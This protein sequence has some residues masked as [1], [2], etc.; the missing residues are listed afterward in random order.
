MSSHVSLNMADSAS[1]RCSSPDAGMELAAAA[2]FLRNGGV[3]VFPT[4]TFYG[5]GCLA[6]NAEAVARVYQLKQRPVHKPLPLLAAHAAQVDA[7]AELAAMPKGLL[8]FWPGPLTVLLPARSCLPPALVN[9]Q[10][11]AAVRVTPHPLAAQLAEQAGG[12][13]T[14]SSAN[15]S[16]GAPVCSPDKLD[17]VLL[18]A[19]RSMAQGMTCPAGCAAQDAK[20]E[21]PL[22]LAFGGPLPAGGLP[23]T[24]VE[25]LS[26]GD[27][28]AGRL[29]IVRA[30]AVSAAALE[31]AGFILG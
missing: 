9:G 14:A 22:P 19:L 27:G 29:R 26:G 21:V 12:A 1:E 8:A 20:T 18:E 6:A 31:A 2:R 11:L 25:P 3:L 17:P 7:V 24:V 10:G 13:L 15:L 5:L 28:G 16:G 23:S 30:G 4:E